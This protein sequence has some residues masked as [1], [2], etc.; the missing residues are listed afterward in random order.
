MTLRD[1]RS[2][3]VPGQWL[4]PVANGTGHTGTAVN[5]L[6]T[7]KAVG[8][9][10]AKVYPWMMAVKVNMPSRS[11]SPTVRVTRTNAGNLGE[12]SFFNDLN[13]I[14]HIHEFRFL[15]APPSNIIDVNGMSFFDFDLARRFGVS[16]KHSDYDIV[17]D[18]LPLY[19]MATDNNVSSPIL[20]SSLAFSLPTRYLNPA[21]SAFQMRVR[22]EFASSS[23]LATQNLGVALCGSDNHDTPYIITRSVAPS[24]NGTVLAFNENTGGGPVKDLRISDINFNVSDIFDTPGTNY[25]WGL[26]NEVQFV[27]PEGPRWHA[28]NDWFPVAGI[29]NQGSSFAAPT[30]AQGNKTNGFVHQNQVIHRPITPHVVTPR[31]QL[32]ISLKCYQDAS[33]TITGEQPTDVYVTPIWVIMIGTQEALV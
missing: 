6:V 19:A 33:Y 24:I 15:A 3:F 5:P 14:V 17:R 8:E 27:P 29:T 11:T 20:D 10:A 30:V 23:I 22:S 25:V 28:P 16:I 18:F 9:K 26:Q 32:D 12:P 7:T 4:G 2:A 1:P 21:S 31:Q 13:R